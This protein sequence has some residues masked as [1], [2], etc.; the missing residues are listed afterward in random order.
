MD[1]TRANGENTMSAAVIRASHSAGGFT[2]GAG[3]AGGGL[4][5]G[6]GEGGG[7]G[8]VQMVQLLQWLQVLQTAQEQF[9]N[10]P[11]PPQLQKGGL[12]LGQ[13]ARWGNGGG[14]GVW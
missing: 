14:G 3:G 4:G 13:E 10:G 8:P 6:G 1:S 7:A 11:F 2:P 5:G 9:W 12:G